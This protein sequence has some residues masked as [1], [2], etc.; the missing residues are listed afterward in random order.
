MPFPV[1]S[2]GARSAK[3]EAERPS[4]GDKRLIVERRSLR[5]ALRAL[6][7]TTGKLYAIALPWWGRRYMSR[8]PPGKRWL[9]QKREKRS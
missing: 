4:L 2:T 3:R 6:V 7:E 1:V 9:R 8:Q 5:A